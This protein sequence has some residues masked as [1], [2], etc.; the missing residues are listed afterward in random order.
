MIRIRHGRSKAARGAFVAAVLVA[1]PLSAAVAWADGASTASRIN[2][3]VGRLRNHQGILGCRLYH[4]EK[5]FPESSSGTVTKEV[6]IT[7]DIVR[8]DFE[9]VSPGTYAVSC[10]HDE[11]K[12]GKLDKNILGVPTEGYGVSNNHTH[13]LSAPTWDESK[14]VVEAG[15]NVGLGIDLRY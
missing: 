12:N 5:G 10:M 6:T 3:N 8:C 13:A 4:A 9:D 15:K 14:F 7:G 11:N 2:I 1:V